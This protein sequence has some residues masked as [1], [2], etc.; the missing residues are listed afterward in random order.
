MHQQYFHLIHFTLEEARA[1]LP[2]VIQTLTR[3]QRL[4]QEL[5]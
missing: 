4:K 3:L 5:D 2:A 1:L